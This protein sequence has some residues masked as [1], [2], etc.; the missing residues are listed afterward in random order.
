MNKK[1]ELVC[2][3]G[4]DCICAVHGQTLPYIS[5]SIETDDFCLDCI[6]SMSRDELL[7]FISI[8][9]KSISSSITDALKGR[10][11]NTKVDLS[12]FS[13]LSERDNPDG[14][15]AFLKVTLVSDKPIQNKNE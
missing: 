13:I 1:N 3:C 7:D 14:S 10:K 4:L 5:T 8:Q 11:D 6:K 12:V 15:K 2:T 9:F